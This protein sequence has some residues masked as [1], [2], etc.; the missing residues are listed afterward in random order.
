MSAYLTRLQI[1]SV[2][3]SADTPSA[4]LKRVNVVEVVDQDGNPWEPEPEPDPDPDPEIGTVSVAP[5]SAA[6]AAGIEQEFTVTVTGGTATNFLYNWTVRSGEAAL[7][8]ANNTSST[9]VYKFD[10][11]GTTQIQCYVASPDASNTPQS[12]ISTIIIPN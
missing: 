7:M 9:A 12:S 3:E 10:T 5:I 2:E 4:Y 8:S 6:L 11:P 1:D